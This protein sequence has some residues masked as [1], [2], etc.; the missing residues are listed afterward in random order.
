MKTDLE[1]TVEQ[2]L[3]EIKNKTFTASMLRGE[4]R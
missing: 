2:C 1:A 3:I 4:G